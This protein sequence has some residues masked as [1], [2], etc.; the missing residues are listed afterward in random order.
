M[1]MEL[2]DDYFFAKRLGKGLT[3]RKLLG[4]GSFGIA[5]SWEYQGQ[6]TDGPFTMHIVIK[7]YN[8]Q[9]LDAPLIESRIVKV[10]TKCDSKHTI[11][12][13]GL[14]LVT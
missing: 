3:G 7:G 4:E 14:L 2:S 6:S 8:T 1:E 10:L 9:G 5:S 11:K 13:C 12:A